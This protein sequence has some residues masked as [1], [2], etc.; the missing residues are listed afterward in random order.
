MDHET[1]RTIDLRDRL[2]DL[3]RRKKVK[4]GKEEPRMLERTLAKMIKYEPQDR[5]GAEHLLKDGWFKMVEVIV[6]AGL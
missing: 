1:S 4:V 3:L 2:G 5:I 6:A